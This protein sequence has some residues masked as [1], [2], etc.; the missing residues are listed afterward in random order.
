[1]QVKKILKNLIKIRESKDISQDYVANELGITQSAYAKLE[2]NTNNISLQKLIEICEIIE[3]DILNLIIENL[4]LPK[5]IDSN[6]IDKFICDIQNENNILLNNSQKLQDK[7]IK[8][9]EN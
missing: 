5:G 8:L 2:S 3:I 7:Y 4:I 9:L 6:N 1:M